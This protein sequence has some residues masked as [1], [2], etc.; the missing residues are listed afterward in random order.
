MAPL[1]LLCSPLPLSSCLPFDC[2]PFICSPPA[3]SSF[4][5]Y[6]LPSPF[7]RLSLSFPFLFSSLS[8]HRLPLSS[9][10]CCYAAERLWKRFLTHFEFSVCSFF[11]E[12]EWKIKKKEDEGKKISIY[13]LNFPQNIC[14]SEPKLSYSP[15]AR[16]WHKD[17]FYQQSVFD[18]HF[19]LCLYTIVCLHLASVHCDISLPRCV[20][21]LWI[22]R[23]IYA[24]R[25]QLGLI[26]TLCSCIPFFSPYSITKAC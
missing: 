10:L 9:L 24:S 11:L 16:V 12:F 1:L 25:I 8:S 4:L 5:A 17:K 15:K 21:P 2:P 19:F 6:C 18:K 14:S 23:Y 7:P 3:S 20:F 26:V 22:L 13:T